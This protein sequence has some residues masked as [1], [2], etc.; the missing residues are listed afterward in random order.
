MNPSR[1]LAIYLGVEIPNDL[2]DGEYRHPVYTGPV[3]R[4][5]RDPEDAERAAARANNSVHSASLRNMASRCTPGSAVAVVAAALD[6]LHTAPGESGPDGRTG[7]QRVLE[8]IVEN[9]PTLPTKDSGDIVM[10]NQ[11]HYAAHDIST[12]LGGRIWLSQGA[13]WEYVDLSAD[14]I[15]AAFVGGKTAA[16]V[17]TSIRGA[18]SPYVSARRAARSGDKNTRVVPPR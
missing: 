3:Y 8:M 12:A 11:W 4:P 1:Q 18:N 14:A 2:P 9:W 15:Y 13:N 16:E 17:Q 10:A 6:Q 7:G 5:D